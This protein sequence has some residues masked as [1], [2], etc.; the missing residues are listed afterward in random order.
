VVIRLDT[1]AP[2]R[3]TSGTT[4]RARPRNKA[5]ALLRESLSIRESL[6]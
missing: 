3:D 2:T 4:R 6:S 5:H 1:G